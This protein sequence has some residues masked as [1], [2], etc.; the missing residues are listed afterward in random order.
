MAALFQVLRQV[1]IGRRE[2]AYLFREFARRTGYA[3]RPP[4]RNERSVRVS[5][6]S[7]NVAE[8]PGGIRARCSDSEGHMQ[9]GE[10]QGSRTG[11]RGQVERL[12]WPLD[13]DGAPIAILH[14]AF[15]LAN[16][17]RVTLHQIALGI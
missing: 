9:Q 16:R 10:Q 12:E 7:S 6:R 14:Q 2:G 3:L 17:K 4:F 8:S 11:K 15:Q 13:G 1:R 5:C